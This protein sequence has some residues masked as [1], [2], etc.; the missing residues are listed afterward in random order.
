MKKILIAIMCIVLII[1]Y[2]P[3]MA[4][5]EGSGTPGGTDIYVSAGGDDTTGDGTEAYPYASLNKAA[6]VVNA[7]AGENFTVHVMSNLESKACARF[8]SK[9]VTIV[10]EGTTAPVVS[11][12]DDF[13]T[14]SDTARSWYNP[15]MVEVQ[16]S[17]GPASLTL[18]NIIFDDCGK[19]EGSK[20]AQATSGEDNKVYVQDAIVASNATEDCTVTLGEGAELRNYGGMSAVRVTDKAKLVMESGSKI[21]DT[22]VTNRVKGKDD[23]GPAGAVWIQGA[24]VEMKTGA[25]ISN[26]IGRAIY[27]DGGKAEIGGTISEIKGDADMWQGKNGTAIH[28]RNNA[29]GTLT[30]TGL[31]KNVTGGG[32]IVNL[33]S[34]TYTM[35]AGSVMSGNQG[36]NIAAYGGANT[37]FM[38]GEITGIGNGNYNAI[39]LQAASNATDLIYCKIGATGNIHDNNVWYGSIYVQGNNIELH[40]YGKINNNSSSDKSGG[41]VLANNMT[42]AKVFMYDGAEVSGNK[43]NNDG[44]GVMVSCGT[45]TMNGGKISDNIAKGQAGGVYVRRGGQFI[46][47]GGEI[48]NNHANK[49][50]GGVSFVASDYSGYVPYVALNGG[51]ISGNTMGDSDTNVSNDLGIASSDYSNI[52]RYLYISNDVTIGNKAVYFEADKKTVTPADDSLGIKLGNASADSKTTLTTASNGKGWDN[53]LAT[54]WMQ[55]SQAATL[56]VGGLNDKIISGLPVYAMALPVGED[57]NPV[58][59]E[60]VNVKVYASQI[61]DEGIKLTIPE[62]NTNGYAVALVQ[63]TEDFGNVVITTDKS[64]IDKNNDKTADG[65][66]EIPYTATYNMSEN[67]KNIIDRSQNSINDEKCKFTFTVELDKRLTAKS[68][69]GDYKFTSPIFDLDKVTVAEDGSTVTAEC[70]LKKDWADH[71]GELLK[72]PMVLTGT[73]VLGAEDF[74]VGDT[75]NT[76][77]HIEVTISVGNLNSIYIPGNVCQTLME[78]EIIPGPG[79][80]QE[81]GNTDEGAPKTGD[82]TSMELLIGLFMLAV[83]ALAGSIF[84]KKS[85]TK[86]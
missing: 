36:N 55:R 29:T 11:R 3:I 52:N 74:T 4:F 35:D 73:G 28:L 10:G 82:A 43:S 71:I 1:C 56:T 37:I 58:T 42:G 45:F 57:G 25:E 75:I 85:S 47:N 7:G 15:A 81:P 6:E 38:N 33:S 50:G 69:A 40:H 24:S 70:K 17:K 59:D 66:Y 49:Y 31:I 76:T 60:N 83:A 26:V 12:G 22:T 9:N 44:A 77:G 65:N 48:S 20:F 63:P 72:T 54:F 34:S 30:A 41:I 84:L 19:H 79:D 32:T 16:T 86:K 46:M 64:K 23:N 27:V 2:M 18:K 8:Y 61:T 51:T 53:P 5:A 78:E 68:G 39:N 13:A 21:I 67:L 62:G 14:Q 80:S